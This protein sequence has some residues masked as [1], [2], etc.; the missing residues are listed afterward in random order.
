MPARERRCGLAEALKHA[1]IAD[2]ALLTWSLDHAA[3]LAALEP[4]AVAALVAA[5][6]R[7]K[8]AV[9]G[10]DERD[11]GG[12]AVLNF[13]HTIGHAYENLLGYGALTHGE[14]VALGMVQAGR[15]SERLRIGPPGLAAKITAALVAVGLPFDVDSPALPT[16]AELVAAAQSDKKADHGGVVFVLLEALGRPRLERLPWATVLAEL[17][18]GGEGLG[19]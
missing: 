19:A 8:A 17:G 10:A 5:C 12:R 6:C 1:L 13:G 14:A 11:E 2:P 16:S 15:L 3:A 18:R 9:V 4:P 7:I